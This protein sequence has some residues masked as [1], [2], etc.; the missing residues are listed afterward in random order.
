M[1][2]LRTEPFGFT[3]DEAALVAKAEETNPDLLYL[4]L[5]NNPTGAVFNPEVIISAAP[6]ET[7]VVID[8]TLPSREIDA[9]ALTRGLYRKFGGRRDLFLVG[10][11]SKSHGTAEY[12]IGWTVCAKPEEA[13]RLGKENRN[14]V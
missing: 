2:D 3:I 14:A 4:S 10:S 7:A 13:E 9:R 5:P 11:T 12:R 1:I 8:L 6:E